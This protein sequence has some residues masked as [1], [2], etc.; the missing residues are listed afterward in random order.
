[1]SVSSPCTDEGRFPACNLQRN[2]PPQ[3]PLPVGLRGSFFVYSH[4]DFCV[5]LPVPE[6]FFFRLFP[7][8]FFV[9]PIFFFFSPLSSFAP[10]FVS[11][12][13]LTGLILQTFSMITQTLTFA[14]L[15]PC[16][17]PLAKLIWTLLF[18]DFLRV[19]FPDSSLARLFILILVFLFRPSSPTSFFSPPFPFGPFPPASLFFYSLNTV[20]CFF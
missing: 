13:T 4:L 18:F 6:D 9:F 19:A 7:G 5:S 2:P 10:H 8:N 17:V 1:L 20:L 11:P 16:W 12:S 14:I 15:S 3:F